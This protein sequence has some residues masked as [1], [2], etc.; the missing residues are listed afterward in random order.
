MRMMDIL[1]EMCKEG[2][3]YSSK[4]EAVPFCA[5]WIVHLHGGIVTSPWS[6]VHFFSA[7]RRRGRPEIFGAISLSLSLV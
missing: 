2:S 3:S 6:I 5:W 4:L 7:I 1:R